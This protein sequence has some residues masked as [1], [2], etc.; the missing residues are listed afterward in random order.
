MKAVLYHCRNF[1]TVITGLSTRGNKITSEQIIN[2]ALQ[3]TNSVVAFI[4]IEDQDNI[5]FTTTLLCDE[6]EK[7]CLDTKHLQVVIVPFAH[8]SNNLAKAKEA[9][10]AFDVIQEKLEAK[11]LITHR[12]HFGSDKSL[13]IEVFGH[14]GNVRFRSF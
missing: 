6:I 2:R 8:L 7:M 9:I 1:Q 4:T 11:N 3:A 14:A 10:R 13:K 5:E 12:D